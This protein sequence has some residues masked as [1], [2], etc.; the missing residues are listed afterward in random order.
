MNKPATA[1]TI[2]F[3]LLSSIVIIA[4]FSIMDFL[5]VLAKKSSA[6]SNSNNATT[7]TS[8]DPTPQMTPH[9]KHANPSKTTSPNNTTTTTTTTNDLPT[10]NETNITTPNAPQ[11]ATNATQPIS[12]DSKDLLKCYFKTIFQITLAPRDKFSDVI[13][14]ITDNPR[15]LADFPAVGRSTVRYLLPGDYRVFYIYKGINQGLYAAGVGKIGQ[16]LISHFVSPSIPSPPPSGPGK[17]L[18]YES[19]RFAN[20]SFPT[21][22]PL[23]IGSITLKGNN[24]LPAHFQVGDGDDEEGRE[25]TLG[26]GKYA[27][28]ISL[29]IGYKLAKSEGACSGIMT[30]GGFANCGFDVKEVAMA[31]KTTTATTVTQ[32]HTHIHTKTII[33]NEAP[34]MEDIIKKLVATNPAAIRATNGQ[35]TRQQQ[36]QLLIP[37]PALS[38]NI[39]VQ[40]STVKLCELLANQTC[41]STQKNSKI[42]FANITKD[43]FGNWILSGEVQ[44]NSSMPLSQMQITMHLYDSIGNNIGIKQGFTTPTTLSPMQNATFFLK[45]RLTDLLQGTSPKYFRISFSYQP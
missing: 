40:L 9:K 36:Q 39:L 20:G 24:P 5:P 13:I 7:T 32:S 34:S 41:L 12:C 2:C 14:H 30:R 17:L 25:V 45:E 33:I 8:S 15:H 4:I 31:N 38:N 3:I 43:S 27:A 44:N 6:S 22:P 21:K 18:V 26:P 16:T 29:P 35:P 1:L 11:A 42:L 28:T 19:I 23:T 37:S 10:T